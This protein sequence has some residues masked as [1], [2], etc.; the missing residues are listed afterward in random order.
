MK[1]FNHP[2]QDAVM[3]CSSCGKGLCRE[4]TVQK[5]TKIYCSQCADESQKGLDTIEA[6]AIGGT[7]CVGSLCY[8]VGFIL[9]LILWLIWRDT[10]PEKAKQAGQIC[11]GVGLIYLIIV[12]IYIILIA[13]YSPHSYY[14]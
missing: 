3:T 7:T 11:I 2:E 6:I 8:G 5:G 13:S 14:Y 10:K 12:I 4:C 1:C 9:P